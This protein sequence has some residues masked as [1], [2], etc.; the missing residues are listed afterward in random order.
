MYVLRYDRVPY[1][2]ILLYC[3]PSVAGLGCVALLLAYATT[4]REYEREEVVGGGGGGGG[5]GG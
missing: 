3:I 2:E 1:N 5:V 4:A